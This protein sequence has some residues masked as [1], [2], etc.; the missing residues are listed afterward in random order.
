LYAEGQRR[1][2][3]S[4]SAYARQ[5]LERLERPPVEELDPVPAAV[6]VDRQASVK[7]SR[8]TVS[9]MTEV[10]DYA[11][12][13]WA[14]AADLYC[15]GC[16]EKVTRDTP[17][18]AAEAALKRFGGE[19]ILVTYPVAAPTADAFL[20]VRD[21]LLADG[22]RRVLVGKEARDLDAV[23]PSDIKK[24]GGFDVVA[25]R[26][27]AREEDRA[28][29]VEAL[30]ASFARGGGKASV[31]TAEG[32][33]F[34]VSS[35][36]HCAR[37]DKHFREPTPG[38]FSFNSP[39]GACNECRG[40]G[41]V[42]TIDYDLVLPDGTRTLAEG[43]IRPWSGKA[44]AW[45]RRALAKFAAKDGIPMDKPIGEF[46]AAER[47][48]L[49]EGTGGK[50][51]KTSWWGL[52]RWFAWLETRAYKMHVRVLLAR[53]RK[54]VECPSCHG[55]RLVPEALRWRV[56][57][58]TLPSFFGLSVA[59]AL[60][61]AKKESA[62]W[63]KDPPT[64][65]LFDECIRR[66]EILDRVGLGYLTLDRA[67]RTLSGGEAQ[68]VGL[69][70]ALSASLSGAMFVL[71]EPTVGLHPSD[72]PKLFGVVEELAHGENLV[73]VV[74]HDESVIRGA[75]RVIEL[76][77]GAGEHGGR[78]VFDGPPSKLGA[79]KTATAKALARRKPT[80]AKRREGK[81]YLRVKKASGHN[82]KGVDAAIPVGALTVV[83]GVSGSG[84]S[85]LILE[86]LYPAV[87]RK[88]GQMELAPPLENGGVEG[89]GLFTSAVRVDQSPLGR[90][91]RGNPATY[92]KIWDELRARLASE[93]AAKERSLTAGAFS[94]NVPGGRCETCKGQGYETVEMQFLA[95]V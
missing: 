14:R 88:L 10:A 13:L 28:R 74:E 8:S 19:R 11:K 47:N 75:D 53:F 79:A 48:W 16:G 80:K 7:T 50:S 35:G 33:R 62:R 72:V 70:S 27:V 36:L 81:A 20:G 4:F 44:T 91:S 15:D 82:L 87:A 9:T 93:K 17:V 60:A 39:V 5:F 69:T 52:R 41:R 24:R 25:D 31:V 66:L 29:V 40:F 58:H 45:E 94:L 32:K 83:T 22:Y 55:A 77:P 84:K 68:R 54:Y 78:I 61:F 34:D 18:S 67:S 1:Y 43:A 57:K 38:L 85:S 51:W 89:A 90:T 30:E 92:M 23:R 6:A 63:T 49:L 56:G 86:T 42:I 59:E 64:T 2:V 3:E 37:C 76:G 46:T 71:D 12:S 21:G 26:A 73:V 95:D 65:L